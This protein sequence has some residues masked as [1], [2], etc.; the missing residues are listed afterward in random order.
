M[1]YGPELP[2]SVVAFSIN[3]NF[4]IVL[5]AKVI[6]QFAPKAPVYLRYIALPGSVDPSAMV[7]VGGRGLPPHRVPN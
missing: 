1:L 5:G 7:V 2:E 3:H 4:E 6:V